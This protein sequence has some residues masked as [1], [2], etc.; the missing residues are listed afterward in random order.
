MV[1]R[2]LFA[3]FLTSLVV[4]PVLA[5]ALKARYAVRPATVPVR[6]TPR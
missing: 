6:R 4:T 2:A 5:Q 3:W 1:A